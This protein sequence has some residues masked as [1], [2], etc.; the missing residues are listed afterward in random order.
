MRLPNPL[1]Q[2]RPSSA[3][4]LEVIGVALLCVGLWSLHPVAALIGLGIFCIL[5]AQGIQRGGDE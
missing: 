2:R 4:A 3:S 1:R 5:I